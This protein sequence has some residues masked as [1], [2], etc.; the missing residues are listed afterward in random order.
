M[1]NFNRI[2]TDRFTMKCSLI[3]CTYNWPQALHLVLQSVSIQTILPDEVI[4]ADDGSRKSTL[5]VIESSSKTLKVPLV[6]SWQEDIGCRIAHSRNR[7]IAKSNYE[8]IIMIDGDTLMHK[9]FI[10]EHKRFAKRGTYIQG[11]RVLLQPGFTK[12]IFKNSSFKRPSLFSKDAK[13][14]I[15]M[16]H[17]PILTMFISN[18]KNNNIRR[19]RGCNFSLFKEDLIKVNGFNEEIATWG[20]EDSEFV[21]RLINLGIYK[22]HLKFSGIQYH[23][24]HN[25]RVLNSKDSAIANNKILDKTICKNLK[26]CDYGIN[27][28]L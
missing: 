23:L 3:I 15:N 14:K 17:L 16:V 7:A 22:R 8:Y 21:Q 26:W 5:N 11:S 20:R 6:H 25:E 4:I 18:F 2:I 27:R 12:K 19:V 13:N 10:K 9:D 1:Y 24:Y 28:Y